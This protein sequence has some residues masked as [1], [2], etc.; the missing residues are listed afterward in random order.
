MRDGL[1]A[2]FA[3]IARLEAA[4]VPAFR[5]LE[6]DLR[7]HGA[8]ASLL[9]S[10][11]RAARDEV[12]HA[13]LMGALARRFGAEP[14]PAVV[15]PV[16]QRALE[17]IAIENAVEGCVREAYGAL[18]A[19]YQS[20]TAKD[21]TIARVMSMIARDETRHAELSYAIDSWARTVLDAEVV[22]RVDAARTKAMSDLAEEI[23]TESSCSIDLARAGLPTPGAALAM[24]DAL[25]TEVVEARAA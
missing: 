23:A 14:E 24:L 20:M 10:C 2:L 16:A 13:K 1:G 18:V 19:T 25:R 3:R 22:A 6:E 11:R 8:P 9:A 7:G 12:R 4:S 5:R 17:T 15:E 21:P